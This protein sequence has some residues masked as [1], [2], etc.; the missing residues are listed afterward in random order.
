MDHQGS[1]LN[2]QI[3]MDHNS[4]QKAWQ[5]LIA[6]EAGKCDSAVHPRRKGNWLENRMRRGLEQKFREKQQITSLVVPE[7][8]KDSDRKRWLIR[9]QLGVMF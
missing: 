1:S 6:K 4:T 8:E 7:K 9:V 2:M 5:H 3:L